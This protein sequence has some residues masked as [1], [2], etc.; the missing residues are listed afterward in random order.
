MSV[1]DHNWLNQTHTEKTK[2]HGTGLEFYHSG[3]LLV[4][5]GD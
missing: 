5:K 1:I 3:Y 2:H 4:V